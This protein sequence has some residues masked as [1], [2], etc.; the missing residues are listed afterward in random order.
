MM[1]NHMANMPIAVPAYG[2]TNHLL[3][4]GISSCLLAAPCSEETV[5]HMGKAQSSWG[6]ETGAFK[7]QVTNEDTKT[8]R[9]AG[10]EIIVASASSSD[11]DTGAVTIS[12]PTWKPKN[13]SPS[14]VKRD[15]PLID[16]WKAVQRPKASLH[17][18]PVFVI[19]ANCS[20]NTRYRKSFCSR[21]VLVAAGQT[22]S[23]LSPSNHGKFMVFKIQT[24]EWSCP[25]AQVQMLAV[26]PA[27]RLLLSLPAHLKLFNGF[28][29]EF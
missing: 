26:G 27:P 5:S 25:R 6:K 9:K 20:A 7:S 15:N 24:N 17:N 1:P 10:A 18:K 12:F 19:Q 11:A 8:V 13:V 29:L 22:D 21:L 28:T 2:G 16:P 3:Q 14:F 4:T 23:S